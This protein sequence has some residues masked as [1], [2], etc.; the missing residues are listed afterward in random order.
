MAGAVGGAVGELHA[1]ARHFVE[2]AVEYMRS[3]W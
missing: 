2:V 1:F 3:V